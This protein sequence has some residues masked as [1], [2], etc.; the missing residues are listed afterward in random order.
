MNYLN[1]ENRSMEMTLG[2]ALY[3]LIED[4]NTNP[5]SCE[6][7][8]FSKRSKEAGEDYD[9]RAMAIEIGANAINY[10]LFGEKLKRETKGE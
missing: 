6:R 2:E 5:K 10:A 9:C 4:S 7:C 8:K 1:K 3:C